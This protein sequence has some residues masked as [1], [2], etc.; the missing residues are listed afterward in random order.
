MPMNNTMAP[1]VNAAAPPPRV[2]TSMSL[3]STPAPT[4]KGKST[5]AR[6]PS[7][8]AN[9]APPRPASNPD[10][11]TRPTHKTLRP[12]DAPIDTS[13]EL[14]ELYPANRRV[15]AQRLRTAAPVLGGAPPLV[16]LTMRPWALRGAS[17]RALTSVPPG[18]RTGTPASKKKTPAQSAASAANTERVP[19][20]A[21]M[22]GTPRKNP[23]QNRT[24]TSC[25]IAYP[26]CGA[27]E[28]AT[29]RFVTFS[30]TPKPAPHSRQPAMNAEGDPS[31]ASPFPSR[32]T[33]AATKA[34]LLRC[35]PRNSQGVAALSRAAQASCP[36]ATAPAPHE[37]KPK[38]APT[39]PTQIGTAVE[40]ENPTLLARAI[41][42]RVACRYSIKISLSR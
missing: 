28:L 1:P 5:P 33:A 8:R 42:R 25:T 19:N 39:V 3:P 10:A 26:R 41:R 32:A 13:E 34:S 31:H 21:T 12:T 20:R 2:T 23:M 18:A 4:S 35:A 36:V 6:S 27:L 37:G 16:N 24:S 9:I 30:N 38:W 14:T 15:A 29:R 40:A 7:A 11:M 22:G 17:S